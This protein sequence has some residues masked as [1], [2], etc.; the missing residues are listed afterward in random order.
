[1]T[2]SWRLHLLCSMNVNNTGLMAPFLTTSAL[3]NTHRNDS[4][5]LAL[6]ELCATTS[7]CP[8]ATVQPH[9]WSSTA[10]QDAQRGPGTNGVLP[11]YP[12]SHVLIAACPRWKRQLHSTKQGQHPENWWR[13]ARTA[14]EFCFSLSY[15]C[16]S[17]PG[18][19]L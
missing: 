19:L 14:M 16:S 3:K 11:M 10:H 8:A 17:L 15:P 1:M 5:F 13:G 18:D 6:E 4:C 2:H 7:P 9:S 12:T